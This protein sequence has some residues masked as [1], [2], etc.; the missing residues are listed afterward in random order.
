MQIGWPFVLKNNILYQGVPLKK[1]Q[2]STFLRLTAGHPLNLKSISSRNIS[3]S[4][5]KL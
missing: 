4:L 3:S 2:L 1:K 5:I